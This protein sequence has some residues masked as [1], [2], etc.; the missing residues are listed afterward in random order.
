MS[1]DNSSI[2]T[3]DDD[4]PDISLLSETTIF[5]SHGDP[6]ALGSLFE[7]DSIVVLSL[8]RHWNC[9]SCQSYVEQLGE[10]VPLEKWSRIG[11]QVVVIGHGV[12][13]YSCI[14]CSML[15]LVRRKRNA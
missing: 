7:R 5:N 11:A 3:T 6:V 15:I 10:R 2:I 4:F 14:R 1:M 13:S 8:I 9:G 12:G